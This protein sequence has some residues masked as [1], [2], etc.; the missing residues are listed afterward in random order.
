[1]QTKTALV[2]LTA[3]TALAATAIASPVLAAGASSNFGKTYCSYLKTRAM[4]QTDSE[5]RKA[6]MAEYRRC[7]KEPGEG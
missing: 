2:T 4:T 5:R 3:A 1:M 7:L 6:L